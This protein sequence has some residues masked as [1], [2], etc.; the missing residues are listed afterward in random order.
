M[1]RGTNSREGREMFTKVQSPDLTRQELLHYHTLASQGRVDDISAS[2]RQKR[3][4]KNLTKSL[5]QKSRWLRC[6]EVY[7]PELLGTSSQLNC[8]HIATI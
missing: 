1:Y 8:K 6:L 4:G 2:I 7:L 3:Q 5:N